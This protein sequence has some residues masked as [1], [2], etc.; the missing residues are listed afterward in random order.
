M[1][2][3]FEIILASSTGSEGSYSG[4]QLNIS[5]I[6]SPLSARKAKKSQ[7]SSSNF[8]LGYYVFLILMV[9]LNTAYIQ[10]RFFYSFIFYLYSFLFYINA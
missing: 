6:T 2:D 10:N 1:T 4:R 7:P 8:L 5:N 3:T 9:E